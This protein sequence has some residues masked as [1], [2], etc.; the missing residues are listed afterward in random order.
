MIYTEVVSENCKSNLLKKKV[1][2]ALRFQYNKLK[3][4]RSKALHFL[5]KF[6]LFDLMITFE[7]LLKTEN[8]YTKNIW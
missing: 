6:K 5:Y 1:A 3:N 2:E 4:V 7:L 8:D